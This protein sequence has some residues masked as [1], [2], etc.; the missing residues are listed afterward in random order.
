MLAHFRAVQSA[1]PPQYHRLTLSLSAPRSPPSDEDKHDHEVDDSRLTSSPESPAGNPDAVL[2][3]SQQQSVLMTAGGKS[4][5]EDAESVQPPK[6]AA[7][8]DR[9]SK[10][11]KKVTA[12]Q[13]GAFLK[14]IK[15]PEEF[16]EATQR[17]ESDVSTRSEGESHR[18]SLRD[19][20]SNRSWYRNNPQDAFEHW[21][22]RWLWIAQGRQ[23]EEPFAHPFDKPTRPRQREDARP[24]EEDTA[25]A[26][27]RTANN[28]LAHS[29]IVV[30]SDTEAPV[31]IAP[32]DRTA[33][34]SSLSLAALSGSDGLEEGCSP[35]S[36]TPPVRCPQRGP[37]A[38]GAQS[39]SSA[40]TT[41]VPARPCQ[42]QA[43]TPLCSED[44][45]SAESIIPDH[46]AALRGLQ[47]SLAQAQA[48]HSKACSQ[49]N[50]LTEVVVTRRVVA[51]KQG[52][53]TS[54]AKGLFSTPLH[55]LSKNASCTISPSSS[56][57]TIA[58]GIDEVEEGC[59]PPPMPPVSSPQ[60]APL[61]DDP[62]DAR[63]AETASLPDA[64]PAQAPT[65]LS[66]GDAIAASAASDNAA[67][68]RDLQK[69]F[70]EAFAAA[71][72]P[73]RSANNGTVMA[74]DEQ[75]AV[76]DSPAAGYTR[77][78]APHLHPLLNNDPSKWT[79]W[80]SSSSPM[81]CNSVE[82][83]ETSS[84]PSMSPVCPPQ[85]APSMDA[86]PLS[87]GAATTSLP[88]ASPPPCQTRVPIPLSEGASTAELVRPDNAA[89]MDDVKLLDAVANLSVRCVTEVN[90]LAE[91]IDKGREPKW[92][93]GL[94]VVL[95]EAK[96]K[97]RPRCGPLFDD[98]RNSPRGEE[99]MVY[100]RSLIVKVLKD[101]K[102]G[103]L[104]PTGHIVEPP[105]VMEVDGCKDTTSFDRLL[106]VGVEANPSPLR[107]GHLDFAPLLLDDAADDLET[108]GW[109]P[110]TPRAS[111][112]QLQKRPRQARGV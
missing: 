63:D 99:T 74:Y 33:S 39:S 54:E 19:F 35:L 78:P 32:S 76:S 84:S 86:T 20:K 30:S 106:P 94:V 26:V 67:T 44:N 104:A 90:R 55:S 3:D 9:R 70:V 93:Q 12:I 73:G 103:T 64:P 89:A 5:C 75:G 11:A 4:Q 77:L 53:I 95:P 100:P 101:T 40:A 62:D 31:G 22:L 83:E 68:V 48:P 47:L 110:A 109:P 8:V 58:D 59:S 27:Q 18:Q 87:R 92:E 37:L 52:V 82:V 49:V 51:L 41:P 6:S 65:S 46:A 88:D 85:P 45:S 79:T 43:L 34:S 24:T 17:L 56:S 21:R 111:R 7:K 14:D 61:V 105:A 66:E 23:G 28:S 42:T 60:P 1:S 80:P 38:S 10:K 108:A 15:T 2:Y 13:R 72:E 57:L 81:A 71:N 25:S 102:Q 107:E 69:C 91:D 50:G 96:A 29:P 112:G 97:L 98:P 16:E 36:R